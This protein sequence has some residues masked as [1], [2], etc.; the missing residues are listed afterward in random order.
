MKI[1]KNVFCLR[2]KKQI[3]SSA[4]KIIEQLEKERDDWKKECQ[5]YINA[6]ARELG[7]VY[8]K[9]HTIDALAITTRALKKK[10]K[11]FE[12]VS[13]TDFR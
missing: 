3:S 11:A 7:E 5:M 1:L 12:V 9:T 2:K 6:W 8:Q 4:Q 10:L 13:K